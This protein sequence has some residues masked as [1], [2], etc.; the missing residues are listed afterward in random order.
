MFNPLQPLLDAHGVIVLDGALATELERRGA[1]L[2]DPLW[3][4]KVLLEQPALIRQVHKDYYRAGADVATTASYQ[5]TFAGFAR[6]GLS[7]SQAA[8]LMRLSVQLAREA[9]AQV[10]EERCSERGVT[11]PGHR[12]SF[13]VHRQSLLVAASIG[14]YGAYLADGSEYRGDYG[15]SVEALMDFHRPR[16]A[17]LAESGADLLACETIPCLAEGEALVRLLADVSHMPAWL[18]FS[19]CDEAPVCHGERFA[20]CVALA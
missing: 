5:A 8:D 12:P 9:R 6:R 13:I 20:D 10:L 19:C 3:S 16:M 18:S 14:P 17:V 2:R 4:A 11:A 1:D 7:H 15:L